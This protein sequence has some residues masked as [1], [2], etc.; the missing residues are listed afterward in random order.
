MN[1]LH[2]CFDFWP[3]IGGVE[4]FV[5]DLARHSRLAG[6]DARVLCMN[7]V[8]Q[9]QG[10]LPARDV[11][12]GVPVRRVPFVNL[13]Y[14]KPALLPL[15]ELRRADVIH[16]H[17]VGALLDF[18]VLTQPLHRKPI[19]LSTHGGLF[20]TPRTQRLKQAYFFK[21]G[22]LVLRRVAMAVACSES[23]FELF[24]PIAKRL[25]LLENGV[26]VGRFKTARDSAPG[27][28]FLY[29]GRF[30]HHKHV[31]RIIAAFAR[32]RAMGHDFSL[33][34]VGPD[35]D[36]LI[37]ELRNLA[38]ASGIASNTTFSGEV[39]E[40]LLPVEFHN[41]DFFV[42]AS[43]YEGFGI[44]VIEA[45]AAGLRPDRQRQRGIPPLHLRW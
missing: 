43:S 25:V 28:R 41:A 14:Y 4:R 30:A 44:S 45:M 2:V 11:V 40:E 13:H 5:L 36:H 3:N 10:R 16:V 26:D 35:D 1:V 15:S 24:R 39:P 8:L 22:P 37:P 6:I 17:S 27:R 12:S 7:R 20:H 34:L 42:S 18:L 21:V 32:L 31:E 38:A 23:D 9:H 33:R 19:V 29:L